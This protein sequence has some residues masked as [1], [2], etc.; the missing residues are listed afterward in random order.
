MKKLLLIALLLPLTLLAQERDSIPPLKTGFYASTALSFPSRLSALNRQLEAANQLSLT[1]VLI[2]INLGVTN[3][4]ADQNSY[5]SS[6]LGFFTTE[7]N[8]FNSNRDTQLIL[9]ELASFGHYD[10]VGNDNWLVYPYLGLGVNY[11]R[12]TVS[13]VVSNASF[14]TSLANPGIEEVVQRRYHTD[15]LMLFG[16]L[17]VG[18]ERVIKLRYGVL[19]VGLSGGYRLSTSRGWTLK[20]VK[21][22]DDSFSTQGWIVQLIIRSEEQSDGTRGSRGLFQ[23]FK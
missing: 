11:A 2:G 19:F 8:D 1:E 5:A 4:F 9:G 14:S 15:G 6:R 20:D 23:F 7:D 18:V 12:L 21:I 16:E 17:G 22:Y 13:S 10:L 3:R